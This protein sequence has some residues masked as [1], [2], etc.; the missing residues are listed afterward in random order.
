MGGLHMGSTMTN[1]T[2]AETI[3]L[4]DFTKQEAEWIADLVTEKLSDMGKDVGS[5]AFNIN[6]ELLASNET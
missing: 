5:F 2:P 1:V 4:C 3:E 6:V